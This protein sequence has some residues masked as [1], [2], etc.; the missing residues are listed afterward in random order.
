MGKEENMV[1]ITIRM[2][3]SFHTRLR[4]ALAANRASA[5]DVAL[6]CLK[7]FVSEWE[8]KQA[9]QVREHRPPYNNY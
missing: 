5:Q 2:P 8:Q 7:G 9:E 6:D 3:E 1:G 4:V